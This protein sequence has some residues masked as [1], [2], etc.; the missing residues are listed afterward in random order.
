VEEATKIIVMGEDPEKLAFK[1]RGRSVIIVYPKNRR[2]SSQ[3]LL[4]KRFI[5]IFSDYA[6]YPDIE[7]LEIIKNTLLYLLNASY[8]SNED[9]VLVIFTKRGEEHTLFFDLQNLALPTLLKILEDRIDREVAE[10]L[11]KMCISIV[12]RGREGSPAGALF[13][14][15]DVT[16]VK[17]YIIQKIA[18]PLEGIPREKRTLKDEENFDTIR[19]FAL[20]D[21]AVIMDESG[22]A[23]S[24][25]AYV[26]NLEIGEWILNG[27]GGRHLAAQSITKFTKAISFVVSSEGIIRIYKDGK[28]IYELK[29]F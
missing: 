22:I 14:V 20:M 4:E 3:A 25:G 8:L 24:S 11:I 13:I 5:K 27:K 12:K 21:G 6:G 18:N 9:K 28:L 23:I 26:K 15:G 1:Y 19:E 10:K 2:P 7:S 17:K 29:D 16:N